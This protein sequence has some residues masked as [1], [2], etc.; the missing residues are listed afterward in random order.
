[1]AKKVNIDKLLKKAEDA[2]SRRNYDLAIFNYLQAVTLQPD[3]IDA[4]Q[5]L[6]ATQ[7][8]NAKE[9]GTSG[10]KAM[11]SYITARAKSA[12]GKHEAAMVDCEN[13]LSANPE[14]AGAL[15]LL[16]S[17]AEKLE[18]WPLVTQIRQDIA[19][20]IAPDDMHNL[21]DLA[22]AYGHL[23]EAH[24]AIAMLNK[25]KDTNPKAIKDIDKLIRDKSA[26]LTSGIY[27]RGVE[28]GSHEILANEEETERLELDGSK[29]RTDE[30]RLKA[31]NYRLEHDVKER[32]DDH[33]TWIT[34]AD[35]AADMKDFNDGYKR[36]KEYLYKARELNQSD[37]NVLDRLADLEIKKNSLQMQALKKK[38]AANPDD[39]E[40]KAKYKKIRLQD[41]EFQISEYERR[42]KAQPLKADFHNRLGQL[43]MQAKR[44]DDAIAELQAATKDPKFKIV[45]R[46]NMGRCLK[47]TGQP[48]MAIEQFQRAREG[49]ELFAKTR[50]AMYWEAQ[51]REELA[52]KDELGKALE[53]YKEIYENDINF[54]DVKTRVPA[55][56]KQVREM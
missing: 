8:R 41:L 15:R 35:I 54:K 26:M 18:F 50:D 1:M 11:K 42:V 56:Q 23:G 16:A 22:E 3:N 12:L 45:A 48:E 10:F 2:I 46:V 53:L 34:I 9:K 52:S 55:I 27:E 30:Q 40:S 47:E 4:R 13:T 37:N 31:I 39:T 21:K 43:Y 7:I 33:R 20:R 36:A 24:Q 49:E 32:P 14:H 44:F 19:D 51:A 29:L 17:S 5:K 38:L 25:I 6:R 28:K